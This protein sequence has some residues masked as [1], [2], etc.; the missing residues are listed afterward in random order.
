VE[1]EL[2]NVLPFGNQA[3]W[4]WWQTSTRYRLSLWTTRN[5]MF[6]VWLHPHDQPPG[7]NMIFQGS[8]P[9]LATGGALQSGRVGFGESA[10]FA[11][12]GN[13]NYWQFT[14]A[15]PL[16]DASAYSS[17]SLEVRTDGAYR[18]E[19]LGTSTYMPLP[20]LGHAPRLP[21][22]RL[23]AS[24]TETIVKLSRGDFGVSP[25]S[26]IDDV[27]FRLFYRPCWLFVPPGV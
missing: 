22:A 18:Q 23:E 4:G 14:A 15:A 13:R 21:P 24:T 12:T 27:S 26:G 20:M 6:A 11:N 3:I 5:G 16:S 2:R 9:E 1:A 7:N 10:A 25:D 8:H 17:R 19:I